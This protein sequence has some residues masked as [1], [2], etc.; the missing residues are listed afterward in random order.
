MINWEDMPVKRKFLNSVLIVAAMAGVMSFNL[1]VMAQNDNTQVVSETA[2]ENQTSSSESTDSLASADSDSTGDNDSVN[3]RSSSPDVDG[4]SDSPYT[5]SNLRT[6][7]QPKVGRGLPSIDNGS[8]ENT[9]AADA[10]IEP[11]SEDESE[12]EEATRDTLEERKETK[13]T[14]KP[15]YH[16]SMADIVAQL[17]FIAVVTLIGYFIFLRA[18]K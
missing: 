6:D 15:W 18:R 3:L 5:S 16:I 11:E 12:S 7:G 17:T 13:A 8:D 2:E 9:D 14:K 4:V 10:D 1:P